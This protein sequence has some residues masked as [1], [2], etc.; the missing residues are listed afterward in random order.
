MRISVALLGV[1]L[2]AA[3]C[4]TSSRQSLV[5]SETYKQGDRPAYTSSPVVTEH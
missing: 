4:T 1:I 5:V 2:L 3:A